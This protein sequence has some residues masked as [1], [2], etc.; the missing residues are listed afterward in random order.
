LHKNADISIENLSKVEGS[1]NLEVKIRNRK[2]KDVRFKITENK[3]FFEEAARG[4]NYKQAPQ[5]MSRICGTCSIAHLL[6]CI[7][8]LEKAMGV[9]VSKQSLLLKKLAMYGLMIRDHALHL[10][11]FAL[12]DVLGKD[13]ILDFD[14]NNEYEHGLL[15]DAFAIKKVGNDLSILVAGRAVHAPY[16]VVG[17]F[18][19]TPDKEGIK[20]NIKG[21]KSIR[22]AILKLI[23][24]Y[25]N[26]NITFERE[27]NFVALTTKDYS[28]L[29]GKIC[30]SEG[31]CLDESEYRN[32]LTKVVIPH[33]QAHGFEIEGEDFMVGSLARLNLSRENLHK[34]TLKDVK[35]YL[36]IFPSNNIFDNNLAQAIEIL[37]SVDHSIEILTKNTFKPEAPKKIVPKAGV[38]IGVIEAPRGTLFYRL[39]VNKKGVI[40][41]ATVI[42]PTQQ[43]Q[44]NIENDIKQL[45]EDRIDEDKKR[46]TSEIET[47]VRAYDP[48]MSCASHFLKV[49]W[50]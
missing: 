8:A 32:Y 43:N 5:S 18:T 39:N 26:W 35:K 7:E 31:K 42:V 34:N 47:L 24:L 19:K 41:K 14:E 12:P 6:C 28:F 17:G 29:E 38:G 27:T 46:I 36:K 11:L 30:S 9:K 45:I 3:R 50:I 20:K 44:L 22:K 33:S 37:H 1:A 15:H 48:C 13:S 10:Y 4:Q 23:R 40:T 21:L 25:Y 16:P 49:K 2:V